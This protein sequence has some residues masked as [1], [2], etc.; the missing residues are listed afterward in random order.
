MGVQSAKTQKVKKLRKTIP[1][2]VVTFFF[3]DFG[4]PV[5]LGPSK[6]PAG[7]A[8][9]LL[10]LAATCCFL[11]AQVPPQRS[12]SVINR[13]KYYVLELSDP[14]SNGNPPPAPQDDAEGSA[15]PAPYDIFTHVRARVLPAGG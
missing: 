12:N 10:L 2:S 11:D 15:G 1:D 9:C 5:A 7:L 4:T 6:G 14:N 3:F 8:A 13:L